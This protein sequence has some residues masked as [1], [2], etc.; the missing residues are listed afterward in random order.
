MEG[1]RLRGKEEYRELRK[2]SRRGRRGRWI[3]KVGEQ[4]KGEGRDRWKVG[5]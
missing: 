5:K 1:G 4:R 2:K 3:L